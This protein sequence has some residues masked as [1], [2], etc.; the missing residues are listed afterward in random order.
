VKTKKFYESIWQGYGQKSSKPPLKERDIFHR[1]F[2]DKFF[3]PNENPGDLVA[4]KL[5]SG[6][7]KFLDIGMWEGNLCDRINKSKLYS[8]VHGVDIVLSALVEAK[9]LGI[10]RLA[11]DINDGLPYASNS[12]DSITMLGVLEH[13]FDP[14]EVL[15]EIHRVL[16][17]GGE[18]ILAVPNAASISNRMRLLFGKGLVTS[19]DPGWDGGHL[20][21]FVLSSLRGLLKSRGFE[22][23]EVRIT[24][25]KTILRSWWP[26]L[27][28]GLFVVRSVV[29]N[30]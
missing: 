11:A 29:S 28:S 6:G 4:F 26:S 27:L 25:G 7:E 12:F 24:G 3:D 14:M 13:V 17:P 18:I 9:E 15:S 16:K 30:K 23:K 19:L 22:P 1:Y 20:H 8:E 2:L 21:Y 5:L 10:I